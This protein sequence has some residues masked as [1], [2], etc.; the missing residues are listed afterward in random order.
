MVLIALNLDSNKEQ[1]IDSGAIASATASRDG[2]FIIYSKRA[3]RNQISIYDRRNSK[4]IKPIDIDLPGVM[5][6]LSFSQDSKWIFF[7]HF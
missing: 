1:I 3:E 7:S 4:N 6:E 2:N 5:G